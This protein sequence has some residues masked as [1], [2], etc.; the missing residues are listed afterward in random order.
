MNRYT[1][2][3]WSLYFDF[4]ETFSI[5]AS[6][7]YPIALLSHFY[8]HIK[9]IPLLHD[10]VKKESFKKHLKFELRKEEEIQLRFNQL[11]P[12][13]PPISKEVSK[14]KTALHDQLLR[15]PSSIIHRNFN[16]QDTVLIKNKSSHKK[17][18]TGISI[19]H[20]HEVEDAAVIVERYKKAW[21]KVLYS[22]AN[23]PVFGNDQFRKRLIK[24]LPRL[25]NAYLGAENIV[26]S[27]HFRILITGTTNTCESRALTINARM[28]G[29]PTVCM[30]H[31]I[32]GLEF[33]YLPKVANIQAVYGQYEKEWYERIGIDSEE[34][35]IIG[36]PR[37]DEI[38][39]KRK[40]PLRKITLR[41][42]QKTVL[43]IHHHEE[44]STPRAIIN[45]LAFQKNIQLIIK[46]RGNLKEMKAL[47]KMHPHIQLAAGEPLYDLIEAADAVVSYPST[48]ALE[49]LLAGKPVFIWTIGGGAAP[50]YFNRLKEF[51]HTHPKSL[52]KQLIL[53]LKDESAGKKLLKKKNE[54]LAYHYPLAGQYKS[55]TEELLK[56]IRA[57][58]GY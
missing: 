57:N 3:Y 16:K 52:V 7:T 28:E 25:L 44:V 8:E 10:E 14:G 38:K 15:F 45:E 2:N 26:G 5:N 34:V 20:L 21:N 43:F 51:I 30:Q 36:H 29:I 27:N 46:S 13:T 54:F 19:L 39:K 47:K 56:L 41:A 6:D 23:H 42:G 55:S 22:F 49:A 4:I 32:I 11:L 17:T 33:G 24:E 35:I 50:A 40:A 31:G 53:Y 37:F 18:N 48:V 9:S 12:K 1:I 58:T